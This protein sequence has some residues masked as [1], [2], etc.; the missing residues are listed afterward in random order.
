MNRQVQQV[1]E[2]EIGFWR[3][4]IRGR[5]ALI[6]AVVILFA[7]VATL[8]VLLRPARFTAAAE[9]FVTSTSVE[10]EAQ[11]VRSEHVVDTV[12]AELG[13]RPEVTVDADATS[14]VLKV[15]ATADT[16]ANAVRV[17]DTYADTY[18]RLRAEAA[19]QARQ[20]TLAPL[21]ASVAEA[22]RRLAALRPTDPARAQ[23]DSELISYRSA[24]VSAQTATPTDEGPIVLSPAV[25]SD[26]PPKNWLYVMAAA[27]IGLLAGI[28]LAG[29]LAG[30]DRRIGGPEL[31]VRALRAP[32]LGSAPG[33]G[34]TVAG[35]GP[36]QADAI[37]LIRS[38]LLP[39][40]RQKLRGS[41]LVCAA[42][43]TDSE[44]AGAIAKQLA[45]SF[46][47]TGTATALV[48]ADLRTQPARLAPLGANGPGLADVVTGDVLLAT[49]VH[50]PPELAGLLVL[51]PGRTDENVVDV[52]GGRRF[53]RLLAEIGETVDVAIVH[54][55]PLPAY[56]DGT[57]IARAVDTSVIV[58]S[59]ATRTD[60]LDAAAE[61]LRGTSIEGIVFMGRRTR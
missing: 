53:G 57:L 2:L 37:A 20:A 28:A 3:R 35:T 45:T 39:L 4:A 14:W 9:V 32:L 18:V 16:T 38:R 52:L 40:D 51:A 29:I 42:D 21:Q 24:L 26:A 25:P 49:A 7:A 27:A 56:P 15:E 54:G 10:P 31:A 60:M 8:V 1:E 43:A 59:A 58:V 47:S 50:E 12:A 41:V 17:A 33:A 48:W 5:W 34:G 46:A 6:L 22:E 44:A 30:F 23:L 13:Y 36:S 19:D 11:F 55:P 61:S